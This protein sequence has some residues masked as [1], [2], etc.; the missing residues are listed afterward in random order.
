L[1][2]L[3]KPFFT[4]KATGTG[5]GLAIIKRIVEAHEGEFKIE[6]S[7]ATGTIVEVLLPLVS[8]A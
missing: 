1:A 2:K 7:A 3:S 8:A 5:L 6:S 4:T